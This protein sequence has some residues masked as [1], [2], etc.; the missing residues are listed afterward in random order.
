MMLSMLE[1]AGWLRSSW[2][3]TKTSMTGVVDVEVLAAWTTSIVF[4]TC[5]NLG[6]GVT[7]STV[8][9]TRTAPVFTGGDCETVIVTV[10]GLL[11]VVAGVVCGPVDVDRELQRVVPENPGFGV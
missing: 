1:T 11:V 2:P 8:P 3:L 4:F 6:S 5:P 7:S 9:T 10:A